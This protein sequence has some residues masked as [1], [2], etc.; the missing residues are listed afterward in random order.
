MTD[1]RARLRH[2][3]TVTR[4]QDASTAGTVVSGAELLT[5][6]VCSAGAARYCCPRCHA[7]FCSARC[8]RCH[9]ELCTEGFFRDQV[10]RH[11]PVFEERALAGDDDDND[12]D[13]TRA[14]GR[15]DA[16]GPGRPA[17]PAAWRHRPARHPT[18][19]WS[20]WWRLPNVHALAR[21][22]ALIAEVHGADA[23]IEQQ[24]EKPEE[25]PRLFDAGSQ[26]EVRHLAAAAARLPAFADLSRRVP[27]PQ[28]RYLAL[29]LVMA[30]CAMVRT[31]QGTWWHDAKQA[32]RLLVQCSAVLASDARPASLLEVLEASSVL[33]KLAGVNTAARRLGL[34]DVCCV[35]ASQPV[36]ACVLTDCWLVA[37]SAAAPQLLVRKLL[38]F[39]AWSHDAPEAIPATDLEELRRLTP[40]SPCHSPTGRMFPKSCPRV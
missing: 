27:S 11:A 10:R 2:W 13:E 22:S 34:Q 15:S 17:A 12:D 1:L 39:A 25:E 5:C 29:D 4:W 37:S 33:T 35:A 16:A 28:L 7:P 23:A 19:G 20:P 18:G 26:D 3:G 9:G 30:Y 6:R 14:A 32:C 21:S 40:E 36:L 38:F 31:V 8:Y 24:Q